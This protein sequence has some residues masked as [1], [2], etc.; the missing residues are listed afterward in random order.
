MGFSF[1]SFLIGYNNKL[2]HHPASLISHDPSVASN[3]NLKLS[4]FRYL[5]RKADKTTSRVSFVLLI[6]DDN[7]TT[8]K[9]GVTHRHT[10]FIW[11]H[12]CIC[13]VVINV[14]NNIPIP[15]LAPQTTSKLKDVASIGH[16]NVFQIYYFVII[17][18][19]L[20]YS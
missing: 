3:Q 20:L 2:P 7:I 11:W 12:L 13:W 9:R 8:A 18:I 19:T 14:N 5:A 1:S 17:I 16:C 10:L 4:C 6:R 15:I